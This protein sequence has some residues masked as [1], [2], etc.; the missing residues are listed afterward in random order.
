MKRHLD[1]NVYGHEA[2]DI[3]LKTRKD[4]S[5]LMENLERRKEQSAAV[6]H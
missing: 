1:Y 2:R 3:E 6:K 5:S 4:K